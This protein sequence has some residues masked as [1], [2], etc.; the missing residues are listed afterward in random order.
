MSS[1]AISL[2]IVLYGQRA[3]TE[4]A[5]DSLAQT[6]GA[7]LGDELELVLVD[8]ASPDDTGELLDAWEDRA[9]VI[10]HPRNLN[11]SGGCNAGAR[12][13]RGEVLVFLNNDMEFVPGTIEAVAETAAQEG[14]GAAGARL[15]FDDGT[16]QHAGVMWVA[17]ADGTP[18][19]PQHAFHHEAGDLTVAQ[20]V[21][22]LDAVT[23]A[24]LA[25]RR[26]LFLAIG[27]FDEEYVNGLEDVDLCLRIRS[28]GL[29]IVYRGDV[30]LVH[31]ES[32]SRGV[33]NV[34][35]AHND[36]L[37]QTRW[38][39]M[40]DSDDELVATAFGARL[41]VRRGL[42]L[43]AHDSRVGSAVAMTG[44][45]GS[46]APEAA[47]ARALLAG[48]ELARLDP[49]ARGRVEGW[50]GADLSEA[51]QQLLTVGQRRICSPTALRIE[52]PVGDYYS[53]ARRQADI[54]RLAQPPSDPEHLDGVIGVWAASVDTAAAVVAMGVPAERVG[55]LPPPVHVA[56]PG[57]GGGGVLVTLPGHDLAR[58][59][60]ILHELSG[61]ADLRLLPNVATP[62]LRRLVADAAPRAEL[63]S[64]STAEAIFV[65]LA[66]QADAMLALDPSDRFERRALLAAAA[67]TPVATPGPG[68]AADVLGEDAV[69]ARPGALRA[70]IDELLARAGERDA[71][72]DAVLARCG[73][74]VVV[75]ALAGLV[76]RAAAGTP[77]LARLTAPALSPLAG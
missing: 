51:E 44:H 12:A 25:V 33:N 63:L 6:L 69:A 68:P 19:M 70:T 50:V 24:C 76:A 46:V 77:V 52:A 56:A 45:L 54:L 3:V 10:R 48:L 30:C 26:E 22:D 59:A 23:A 11:F 38:G 64:P 58:C 62:A 71:R 16:L 4:R 74:A 34:A 57:I 21:L 35:S 37:F 9:V 31:H 28:Q 17:N 39:G 53:L 27:G 43:L 2:I 47:E 49:C 73:Y 8:N 60:A 65:A 40:C 41:A 20:A 14:V 29:R 18:P 66:G 75:P 67:G 55:Y 13:A 15:L 7:K 61:V 32:L 36:R 42:P 1:P 72:H 5:L